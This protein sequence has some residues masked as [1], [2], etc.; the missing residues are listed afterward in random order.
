MF[1]G[2]NPTE[3]AAFEQ[4]SLKILLKNLAKP[5]LIVIRMGAG[6]NVPG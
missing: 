3:L 2:M 5:V 6:P 1:T 4:N